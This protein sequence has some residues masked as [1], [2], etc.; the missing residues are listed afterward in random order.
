MRIAR[1]R[2]LEYR[3]VF[4]P[5]LWNPATVWRERRAPLLVLEADDGT[6]GL[7]E[8][9]C[10]QDEIGRAFSALGA[11]VSSLIGETI[12]AARARTAP[13]PDGWPMA[14]AASAVDMA[15]ADL[16]A[17][18][19]GQS[20]AQFLGLPARPVDVYASGGLYGERKGE[21]ELAAEM[22][23]YV[24]EGF[25]TVKM[26]IGGLDHDSDLS[27]VAAVRAAIGDADL[28]VDGV[29]QYDRN[30]APTIARRLADLG[31]G[32]FQAPLPADD[33]DGLATLAR[34]SPIPLILGEAE[35][36]L[37]RLRRLVESGATGWLQVNPA[38]VGGTV[39]VAS[40]AAM[41]AKSGVPL[42]LQCHATAI[43]QAACLHLGAHDAVNMVEFHRVHDH[44]HD[45]LPP[46]LLS[47][48]DGRIALPERPGLALS[49]PV[50]WISLVL[51]LQA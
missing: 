16:A 46:S 20:L 11:A 34:T 40:L 14:G 48:S 8:A 37:H 13:P 45:L 28:I 42:T 38:L 31:V 43:L 22:A 44:L 3:R 51:E 25:R 49:E 5:P 17:R 50:D 18:A 27:R 35:W 4:D 33:I 15:L 32:A 7:G 41:V 26:K 10:R 9:W 39:G 6:I 24:A 36:D 19:A 21:P 30:S 23:G 1:A 47:L 12:E 29:E 2:I